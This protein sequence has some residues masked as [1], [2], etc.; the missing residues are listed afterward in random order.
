MHNME[1]SELAGWY[2]GYEVISKATHTGTSFVAYERN[3]IVPAVR[4]ATLDEIK[5]KIDALVAEKIR[6]QKERHGE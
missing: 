4:A 6:K 3:A 5:G 1:K 2:N